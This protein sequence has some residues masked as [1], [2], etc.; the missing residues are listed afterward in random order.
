MNDIT[1]HKWSVGGKD[2]SIEEFD[3]ESVLNVI[4]HSEN[5]YLVSQSGGG[6]SINNI[7]ALAIARH[8]GLFNTISTCN[9]RKY[10]ELQINVGGEC[11]R[12]HK[13]IITGK[14]NVDRQ[15]LINLIKGSDPTFE[16]MNI[17]VIASNGWFSGSYSRWSWTGNFKELDDQGLYELYITLKTTGFG[18]EK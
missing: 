18:S 6:V 12:C 3:Y 17:P 16:Q 4:I 7:D 9:C 1:S 13:K 14:I 5:I 10:N 11:I 2:G 8:F 15:D